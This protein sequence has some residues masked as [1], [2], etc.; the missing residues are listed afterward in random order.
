MTAAPRQFNRAYL[1]PVLLACAIFLASGSSQLATPDIGLQFS[2]DKLG[3]FLIFGLLAT[4]LLRTPPLKAG[5]RPQLLMAALIACGFGA[6]D[7]IRQ[8]FTPGRSVELADWIAD[9]LG[10]IIAVLFY[11]R[12]RSYRRLLAL[13][14]VLFR[15]ESGQAHRALPQQ[16]P[17][18][19][20]KSYR[21]TFSR[22]R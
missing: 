12:W 7:E 10:A 3:H 5:R 18:R 13:N 9:S 19:S 14:L 1:W 17:D 20:S 11:A 4:S 8:S 2:K 15:Q 22:R 16:L 6:F 21:D